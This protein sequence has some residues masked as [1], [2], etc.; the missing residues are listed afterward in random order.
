MFIVDSLSLSCN[1]I[2]V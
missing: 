2:V 1:E